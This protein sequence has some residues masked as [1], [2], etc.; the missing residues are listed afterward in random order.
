MLIYNNHRRLKVFRRQH[1]FA[2]K[3]WF[4]Q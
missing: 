2:E 3:L 1:I 4:G